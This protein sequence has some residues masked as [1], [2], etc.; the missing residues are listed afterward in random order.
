MIPSHNFVL[1]TD[2]KPVD[3]PFDIA[4]KSVKELKELGF[5]EVSSLEYKPNKR[6]GQL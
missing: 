2:G 1:S 6:T 5:T 4:N 3:M